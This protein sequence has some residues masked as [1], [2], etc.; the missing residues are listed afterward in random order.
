[1]SLRIAS[2]FVLFNA[3]PIRLSTSSLS[4]TPTPVWAAVVNERQAKLDVVR[5]FNRT[6]NLEL[7]RI[8]AVETI[9][10]FVLCC[11][12]RTSLKSFAG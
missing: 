4:N 3:L 10:C 8:V 12:C 7:L 5:R 9:V 2:R 6:T 1:M 11:G